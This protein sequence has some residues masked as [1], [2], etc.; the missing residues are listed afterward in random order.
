MGPKLRHGIF[1]NPAA[2]HFRGYGPGNLQFA[3]SN[4][5]GIV[6][7]W[8][9]LCLARRIA[10]RGKNG[11]GGKNRTGRYDRPACQR[12]VSPGFYPVTGARC[13]KGVNV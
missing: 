8:V 9:F 6:F 2:S 12:A 10:G 5:A 3:R 13:P 11:A 4:P 1:Q 7:P